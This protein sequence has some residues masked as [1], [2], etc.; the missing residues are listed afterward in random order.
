MRAH[1]LN[2]PERLSVFHTLV[3]EWAWVLSSSSLHAYK[4]AQTSTF[5]VSYVP[6]AVFVI[7]RESHSQSQTDN[8]GQVLIMLLRDSCCMEACEEDVAA[9][10][11]AAGLRKWKEGN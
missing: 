4:E 3:G 2:T 7:L 9:A 6:V 11:R 8:R 10:A 1:T 5:L